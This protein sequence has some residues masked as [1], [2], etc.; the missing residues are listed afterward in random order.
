MLKISAAALLALA[1]SAGLAQ[2]RHVIPGC[3]PGQSAAK[4]CACGTVRGHHLICH[5][6]QWCH[7]YLGCRS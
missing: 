2:A 3:I 1:M 4:T 6:G 5:A 7:P